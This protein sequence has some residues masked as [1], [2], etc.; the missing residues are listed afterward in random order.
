VSAKNVERGSRRTLTAPGPSPGYAQRESV[1]RNRREQYARLAESGAVAAA[2]LDKT[3]ARRAR[4]APYPVTVGQAS[5]RLGCTRSAAY[6]FLSYC[7]G[8]GR[9]RRV[10]RGLY[11]EID[12]G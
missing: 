12:D 5:E 9:L 10:G 6:T 7:V 8:A 3:E 4:L 11:G 1:R 2:K